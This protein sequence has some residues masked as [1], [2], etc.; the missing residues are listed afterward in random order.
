MMQKYVYAFGGE[1]TEGKADMRNL[2]GSKGANLAEMASLGIQVPPGFTLSTEACAYYFQNKNTLPQKL[3]DEV[4]THLKGL[5]K[6]QDKKFGDNTNPLLVA[7]R[8]G[9]R[10]SMPGM[11]DTVLNLGLNDTSVLGLAESTANEWFAYDSYRRFISMFGNVV[12][13]IPGERF[14]TLLAKKKLKRKIEFDTELTVVELKTLVKQ[15]KAQVVRSTQQEFPEDVRVQL[16]MAIEAVFSSWNTDRA[17]IYRRLNSIP[18]EWG[19][20]VTVQSMVFGNMGETSATGVAFTRNPA[21]GEKKF[22]GEYMINAQGEDVVAGIRTPHSIE[23]L[24]QDMPEVFQDLVK[25]YQKLENYYKDMQDLEFTIE[26]RKLFLLQ[27]RAGKRTAS[28]AI[29]IAIDMVN[30]GLISKREAL[31]RVPANQLDQIFHPMIDPKAKLKLLGKGLGASPGAATGKIVFTPERAQE[32]ADKKEKVILVRMETSPEDIH[33]MSVSQAILTAKGGMTSHAAVVARAMGKPCVSGVRALEVNTKRKTCALGGIQLKELDLITLDGTT[34]RVIKGAPTLIQSRLTSNFTRMMTWAGEIRSLA[35]RANADTPHDALM[36][37]DFGAQGIGLCRTEHMFFDE[38]RIFLVRKMILA[39]DRKVRDEA[40]K[41]LLPIQRADFTEIFR[42]MEGLPIT[43]RL[44][45]P[46]LHEFLPNS[47]AEI[48][49]LAKEMKLSAGA[50]A[51]KIAM[52]KEVNP[53]LGHRGCRLGITFPEIYQMQVRAIVEAAC[54]QVKKGLKVLPE[55]MVPLVGHV[56]EF[57]I[58][59]E[60]IVEVAE[61]VIQKA[62]VKLQYKIGTMIELPRA[63]LTADELAVQADFFSFGTNDLTQTAFGLSRDD[64]GSFLNEYLDMDLLDKD[65][66][67]SVDRGG[68]GQ[69]IGIAVE[70]G[71]KVKPGLHLGVCG[72]HGGDPASI[73]FFNEIGLDYVSCSPYR[74]PTAILAAAQAVIQE[75]S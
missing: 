69:L 18:H 20:G 29:K 5:E 46:P 63:A 1:N 27:T 23:K 73:Q 51:K 74:V 72:E 32:L 4:N 17:K 57:K 58:V 38:E 16:R 61:E 8:S 56:N 2:L 12:L 53:M 75:D 9:A 34:G 55:I 24:E 28:S 21:T 67:V 52:M 59:H 49:N 48:K 68:V 30:E 15:F 44:L 42:V 40:L 7:V 64:S 3:W 70:K 65:P 22:Y 10:V 50:L 33:G 37:R 47:S 60:L 14:E 71:K 25:V 6:I 19:T 62:G 54:R 13:G 39:G 35:I 45:D 31:M 11:M 26:N 36:A 43:I 66:F 41:K